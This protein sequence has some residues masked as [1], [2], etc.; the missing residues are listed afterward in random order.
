MKKREIQQISAMI[1]GAVAVATLVVF[2]VVAAGLIEISPDVGLLRWAREAVLYA[3]MNKFTQKLAASLFLGLI[4]Y[5]TSRV[6]LG[7]RSE[8]T[9]RQS[10]PAKLH[11]FPADSQMGRTA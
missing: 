11:C 6:V 10:K 1:A 5:L 7:A 3:L 9:I 8:K 4:A 2:S